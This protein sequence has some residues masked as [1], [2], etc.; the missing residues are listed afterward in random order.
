MKPSTI[1][2]FEDQLP[3]YGGNIKASSE[4]IP[5][6]AAVTEDQITTRRA[7]G[8]WVCLTEMDKVKFPFKFFHNSANRS[9][10]LNTMTGKTT[11]FAEDLFEKKMSLVWESKLAL[12]S[13]QLCI[14]VTV[15]Q[16]NCSWEHPKISIDFSQIVY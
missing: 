4:D 2:G 10:L 6:I 12:T 8:F 7:W 5:L 11:R 3:G 9:F 1:L 15:K 14:F 13:S 16:Y